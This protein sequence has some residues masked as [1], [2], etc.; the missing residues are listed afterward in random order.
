M[1][2]NKFTDVAENQIE[3][4]DVNCDSACKECIFCDRVLRKRNGIR[5]STLTTT[6]ETLMKRIKDILTVENCDEKLK[7][8]EDARCINYHRICLS[9]RQH[10]LL[11]KG[12][13]NNKSTGHW[14]EL[15]HAHEIAFAGIK[16][17]VVANII[18]TETV[19]TLKSLFDM[20]RLLFGEAMQ[21][22]NGRP[23]FISLYKPQHFCTK[24]LEALPHLAKSTYKNRVYLHSDNLNAGQ[25]CGNL[26]GISSDSTSIKSVAFAIRNKVLAQPKNCLPKQNISVDNI[27]EGE[28]DIPTDLYSFI[29]CLLTGPRGTQCERKLIKIKSICN[30][31][32]FS[33]TNG[34]VR[35][36][37]CLSLGLVTKSIT[38]S[39]RM[40]QILNKL[41][42]SI[43]YSQ[44]EELETEL[45]YGCAANT[46]ILPYNLI[47]GNP[48]LRTHVAFDNFD[49]YVETGS[50]KN[51]L[52]DTVGIVY[53]NIIPSEEQD[54]GTVAT[55]MNQTETGR[56]RRKYY[57]AFDGTVEPY[58]TERRMLPQLV[59]RETDMPKNLEMS[60]HM[61]HIW[62]LHHFF[63]FDSATRWFSWNSDRIADLNPVQRIGYLPNMNMSPT[64]DAAV[65][66]TLEIA[67]KIADECGQKYI[68]VTYDLAIASKAY[69]IQ[70]DVAPAFDRVFIA[71]GAFHIQLSFFKVWFFQFFVDHVK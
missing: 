38:G 25:L 19:C 70:A 16:D 33:L 1:E 18:R 31:I 21:K 48:N 35:P 29:S 20:Y 27:R 47:P 61:D 13:S 37:S 52:H 28:C 11:Y 46:E 24:L 54:A 41:G 9:Q 15:R 51:T 56:R 8:I 64:S 26:M 67:L 44:V 36:S 17:H 43:S 14:S 30:S 57:S 2:Y 10:K 32:I 34:N 22:I 40:V 23:D 66:K 59:D 4:E 62:M 7:S 68:V 60:N 42:H 71:L 55:T 50:G 3:W 39:R 69:R 49:L 53:Q 5:N 6:S 58:I 65:H 12:R 45:A 63:H